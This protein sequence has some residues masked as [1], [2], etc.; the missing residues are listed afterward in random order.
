MLAFQG[1]EEEA[2][3]KLVHRNQAKVFALVYRLVNDHALAEDLT[4]EAFLRVFRTAARYQPMARFTTWLHRIAANVALNAIRAQRKRRTIALS[5]PEGEDGSSWFRDVPDKRGDP[6]Q[7]DLALAELRGRLTSAIAA[8][9][10]NQRI[11]IT[12]NKYEHMSYQEIAD[13]LDCSTM[14]VKSL[15]ARARCNL[16][17]A[18]ARYL[19][20]DF[21]DKFPNP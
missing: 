3:T 9:P 14:A 13:I 21:V 6:P 2:F 18:L 5:M 17:D 19:G 16:R 10:Q 4:Q 1:G 20:D 7:T 12:L 11:A 15:L 8:L